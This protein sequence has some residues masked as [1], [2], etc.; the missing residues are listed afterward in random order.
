M[1]EALDLKD[2]VED[3]VSSYEKRIQSI[4]SVFDVDTA[5]LI[6]GDS[7]GSLIDT[8]EKRG[9][10]N[11][12][13][14]DILARKEHLRKKDFDNMMQGT[15]SVQDQREKE[16]RGLLNTYLNEQKEMAQV[17]RE[18]L[19][20]FRNSL[21]GGEVGR[22]KEFQAII[23]EVLSKQEKRKEEITFKLKD[24]QK[25]Q[26]EMAKRLKELLAKGRELRIKDFKSML[27]EFN[28]QRDKRLVL[29]KGRKQEVAKMLSGFREER[30]RAAKEDA[31]KKRKIKKEK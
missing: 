19:E 14:R 7:Q 27:K 1:P 12:Q 25:E 28:V 4:G 6:F 26:Q 11:T 30:Q 24:F 18:N 3:V 17:L 23:K 9:E 10:I 20:K 13:L 16:V 8:R 5:R 31:N 22:V 15:L 2:V 21:A 29:Q